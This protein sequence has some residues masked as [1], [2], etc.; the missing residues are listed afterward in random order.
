MT[1]RMKGRTD[2]SGGRLGFAVSVLVPKSTGARTVQELKWG[3]VGIQQQLRELL[4]KKRREG[5]G[6]VCQKPGARQNWTQPS[7]WSTGSQSAD[8]G[9]SFTM[10]Q[11]SIVTDVKVQNCICLYGPGDQTY[12]KEKGVSLDTILVVTV[13]VSHHCRLC[14][15]AL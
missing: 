13:S 8:R 14:G 2:T 5:T 4:C 7:R 6:S 15:G 12:Y 3:S 11:Q 10:E 9:R 1:Y